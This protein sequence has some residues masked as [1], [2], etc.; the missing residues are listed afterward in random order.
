MKA[1]ADIIVGG[2]VIITFL[3]LDCA[4][5]RGVRERNISIRGQECVDSAAAKGSKH[6]QRAGAGVRPVR[7]SYGG[8][9]STRDARGWS[10]VRERVQGG[11]SP[12]EGSPGTGF[13]SYTVRNMQLVV[14]EREAEHG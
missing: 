12:V 10:F 7:F 9:Q 13:M 11:A 3:F 2:S 14:Q 1:L 5:R 6:E 4:C 8:D